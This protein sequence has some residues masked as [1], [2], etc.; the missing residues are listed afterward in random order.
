MDWQITNAN[1]VSSDNPSGFT[2]QS[3]K[4]GRFLFG[5]EDD[6]ELLRLNLSGAYVFPALINGHDNLLA[7]FN[8]VK[9]DHFPHRFWLSHDNDVKMSSLFRQRMLL[10]SEQ[11]YLL[12]AYKNILSGV[13]TVV[14][15]I[16]E[17]VRQPFQDKMPVKLLSD[18]GIAHSV[19]THS[20]QWGEGIRKE[21]DRSSKEGNPFI[22][23]INE[24]FDPESRQSLRLLD[25]MGALGENTV[26]IHGLSLSDHDLDRIA[27]VGAKIVVCPTMNL[28]VY[29]TLPPIQKMLEREICVTMGTDSGMAGGKHLFDDFKVLQ[30]SVGLTAEQIYQMATVN[31]AQAFGLK[32]GISL[33]NSADF[34]VIRKT[35]SGPKETLV[36]ADLQDVFLLVVDGKPVY[37]DEVLEAIFTQMGIL[38]DRIQVGS[39][40]K[41]IQ[42]GLK[43]LL[44]SIT[45]SMGTSPKFDF[46]PVQA[47]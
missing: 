8:P 19:G 38:F 39:N 16:P 1:I 31:A 5:T 25:E 9:G 24:G 32:H 30:K 21:Y 7:T 11:L 29:N 37:A 10:E 36:N 26:L 2:I 42:K 14:D 12:G 4:I 33:K 17:F 18:F 43:N 34:L 46:L 40:K 44:D 23:H 15:H 41:I 6:A 45:K 3:G 22:I 35:N 47:N 28:F 27:K 13:S 20:L